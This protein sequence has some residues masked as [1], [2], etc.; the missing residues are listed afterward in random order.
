[1]RFRHTNGGQVILAVIALTGILLPDVFAAGEQLLHDDYVIAG[2]D[3]R[4]VEAGPD[5][6][7]FE[8]EAGIGPSGTAEAKAGQTL[9]MLSSATLEK[10][11]ADAKERSD[12][13]YR[14]WGKVTKF[15]GKN[16]VF[17]VYFLG[18]RKVD[19]PAGQ[20]QAD[21]ESKR[22]ASINAPNDILNIPPE[23]AAKLQTSEVLPAGET[24]A[25]LQLKQDAIFANRTGRVVE[26]DGGSTGL[27]TGRYVFEPD[28]LGRGIEK[29][30]IELLPC[31]SL[32]DAIA[33]IK[34]EPNPVRFNVAGILTKYKDGQCLLLQKA[35]RVYSYGN[36]GK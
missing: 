27:A 12:A 25:A 17:A 33:Q 5:K 1:M 10:M 7:A 13:R 2:V 32:E 23:I 11:V 6:W 24:P 34:S 4:L 14:L 31:Q 15:E 19:R 20:P 36:F 16:Y 8:F 21:S 28:G 29:F 18:L 30:S 26:K 35:T 9:E 3:G 22:A